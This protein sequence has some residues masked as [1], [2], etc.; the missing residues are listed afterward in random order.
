MSL[1]LPQ[2]PFDADTTTNPCPAKAAVAARFIN[3]RNVV[4]HHNRHQPK[5]ETRE[6]VVV[7]LIVQRSSWEE[8]G[9]PA[10]SVETPHNLHFAHDFASL[11]LNFTL[12]YQNHIPPSN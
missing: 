11:I 1:P 12:Q 6:S 2:T 7:C 8:S 3:Q 4:S 5:E 9:R 10:D